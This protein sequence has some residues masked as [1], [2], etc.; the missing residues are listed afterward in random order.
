[1]VGMQKGMLRL[2]LS[3]AG[4]QID[5]GH[6][7]AP[8]QYEPG[9]AVADQA[10]AHLLT[11]SLLDATLRAEF[12]ISDRFS[13]AVRL[14]VRAVDVIAD[15]EG[16]DGQRLPADYASIHH[17]DELISGLGDVS[18]DAVWQLKTP[19]IYG[20]FFAGLSFPT[21]NTEA[22]PF[23]RGA[24]GYRHQHIFLGTG[25]I[26]PRMGLTI[27]H[28]FDGWAIEGQGTATG[29]VYRNS[30]FFK[31]GWRMSGG[32]GVPFE[33]GPVA[34]RPGLGMFVE[35]PARWKETRAVN[36]GRTDLVPSFA[37]SVPWETWVFGG[38]LARP[39]NLSAEGGQV[40]IP[41]VVS[42]SIT[43]TLQLLD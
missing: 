20:R 38:R 8:D 29:A 37:V 22:D 36:S 4:T 24:R 41:L 15:F 9:I 10:S 13:V 28:R 21:G 35:T 14:P 40:Q 5:A 6:T 39:I 26:D 27:G 25:T 23:V 32:V 18:A 33:V 34:L 42:L 16:Q 1:M 43:K 31:A 17:R 2:S 3:F 30:F 11:I 19:L 12:G 7:V